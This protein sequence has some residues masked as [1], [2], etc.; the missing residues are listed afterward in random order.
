MYQS[1]MEAIMARRAIVEEDRKTFDDKTFNS[2]FVDDEGNIKVGQ[3]LAKIMKG[4]CETLRVK[5]NIY[6]EP[7]N[8]WRIIIPVDDKFILLKSSKE[9]K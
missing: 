5:E 3:S 9:L 4:E 8:T 1:F 6:G 2:W 7:S